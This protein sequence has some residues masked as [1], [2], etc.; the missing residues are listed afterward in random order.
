MSG[1]RQHS[2]AGFAKSLMVGTAFSALP[3]LAAYF[4]G[5]WL[6]VLL[7]P[8]SPI[9]STESSA[10]YL[11]GSAREDFIK[12]TANGCMQAKINDEE[13]KIIPNSLFEGHCHCYANILAD[14]ITIADMKS[15]N[16]TVTDPIVKAAAL[17]CYQAM[18][19][20]ALRLYNAG[21]YPKQ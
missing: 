2:Q 12:G 11:T 14:K 4:F 6:W 8:I 5:R 10:Q 21:Q 18:K 20:E 9:V 19:A 3:C 7:L 15:D 1:W 13:A 16:K 17:S